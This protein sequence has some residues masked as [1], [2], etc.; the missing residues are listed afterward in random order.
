[1]DDTSLRSICQVDISLSLEHLFK[2]VIVSYKHPI[3]HDQ[4]PEV[5]RSLKQL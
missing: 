2:T 5:Q 3:G 1:M 4:S